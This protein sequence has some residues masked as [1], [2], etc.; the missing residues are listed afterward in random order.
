MLKNKI[1]LLL[2]MLVF[3][4]TLSAQKTVKVCGEYTCRAPENVSLEQAKR[5]VLEQAKLAALAEHFG[6]TITQWNSTM[7]K[8]ENGKS[9]ISFLSLG[10]SDVKGEW[11]EDTSIE[12]GKPYYEQDMLVLS[13]SVCG[14]A[15]EITGAGVD[16]SAKVLCNGTETKYESDNF[17]NGDDIYLLFRSPVDGY[18]AVYLVDDSQ[19]AFCL[20]PYMNDTQGKVRIKAGREYVFFSAKHAEPAEKSIVSEYTMICDKSAEQ[21]Y[22]YIIFSPNEF[23]KA[24]D[25]NVHDESARVLPRELPFADFQKWLAKNRQR[26]RDMKVEVKSLMIKK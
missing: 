24:N 14:K 9:D 13:V 23:T 7:V 22:L 21:N 16:F 4:A 6:T 15:R 10:G 19:T 17:R 8:N 12:Y 3:S 1:S 20:L 26:D 25:S 11:L 18:P 5:F 2:T